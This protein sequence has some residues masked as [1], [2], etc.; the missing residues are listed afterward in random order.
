MNIKPVLAS[1]VILSSLLHA[2]ASVTINLGMAELF[3]NSAA[4][5]AISSGSLVNIFAKTSGTWGTNLS[6][7]ATDFS[8][9]TSSFTPAGASLIG[10][11]STASGAFG[12]TAV[13]FNLTGGLSAGQELL[14]VVYP[15]LTTSS[16]S[17]GSG[18]IGFV[19]RTDSVINFSDIAWVIPSDG[20]TVA[21]NALTTGA[22]GSLA[23]VDLSPGG[24]G[25]FTT[26]PEPSTYA[27]MALGGL[28]LF[29]IARR[30]KA[31]V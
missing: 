31:Q 28:A 24:S 26:V 29:F 20:N 3:S 21:L 2:N 23:A 4:T 7:I 16:S 15:T 1:A 12:P 8:N 17:P 25:G 11:Y 9:L 6:S 22:G 19:Y 27:L 14:A 30:R 5:T 13:T 10:S 18:T